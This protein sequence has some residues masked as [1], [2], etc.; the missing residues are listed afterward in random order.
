MASDKPVTNSD[1]K[2]WWKLSNY[3]RVVNFSILVSLLMI[4]SEKKIF[5]VV[6][7]LFAIHSLYQLTKYK[8]IIW[9]KISLDDIIEDPNK[10]IEGNK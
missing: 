2:A 6:F 8:K 4:Q 1:M 7:I 3:D 9:D 5:G 10:K